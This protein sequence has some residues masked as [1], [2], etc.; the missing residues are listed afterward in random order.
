MRGNRWAAAAALIIA[1]AGLVAPA[2]AADTT[3]AVTSAYGYTQPWPDATQDFTARVTVTLPTGS[4]LTS[5]HYTDGTS[6]G[7]AGV[8]VGSDAVH[9]VVLELTEPGVDA[10]SWTT[11][12]VT[13]TDGT[14]ATVYAFDLDT[15]TAATPTTLSV[16]QVT[17]TTVKAGRTQTVSGTLMNG[18]TPLANK[19]VQIGDYRVDPACAEGTVCA[20]SFRYLTQVL[21]DSTG[22]FSVQAPI[23]WTTTLAATYCKRAWTCYGSKYA[24]AYARSA[25]VHAAWGPT[26]TLPAKP[27]AHEKA[28]YKV[29]VP[30]SYTG[31]TVH[32]QARVAGVW[33]TYGT[34]P[35][36]GQQTSYVPATLPAGHRGVRAVVSSAT[37]NPSSTE[38][39]PWLALHVNQGV[40]ATTLVYVAS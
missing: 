19:Y 1:S 22:H 28:Y 17:D 26:L 2:Q 15:V 34:A 23:G 7:D 40:S 21:T 24:P 6:T 3:W 38:T 39:R 10:A 8:H 20:G 31:V 36:Q 13:L 18:A 16:D 27:Q 11:K 35:V 37:R 25:L 12:H 5:V 4:D 32:I 30:A 14:G 29:T 33:K 9:R